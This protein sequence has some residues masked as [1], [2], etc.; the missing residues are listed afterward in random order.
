MAKKGAKKTLPQKVELKEK[1]A[2]LLFKDKIITRRGTP[3]TIRTYSDGKVEELQMAKKA[4]ETKKAEPK[5]EEK[6]EEKKVVKKEVKANPWDGLGAPSSHPDHW[7]KDIYS[8]NGS[9]GYFDDDGTF[10]R[11]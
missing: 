5:K 1:K 4:K 10:V 6:K 8:I 7:G 11:I 3:I 2:P 9:W